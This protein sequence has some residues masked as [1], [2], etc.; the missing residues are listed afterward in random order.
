MIQSVF[1]AH[2]VRTGHRYGPPAG[3][4]DPVSREAA[5]PE[6]QPERPGAGLSLALLLQRETID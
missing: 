1:R 4:P 2:L 6:W 3:H 5:H